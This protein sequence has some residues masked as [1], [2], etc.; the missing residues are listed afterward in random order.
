MYE[1]TDVVPSLSIYFHKYSSID[2]N[3]DSIF[4]NQYQYLYQQK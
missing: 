2:I 3:I 1:T 4:L